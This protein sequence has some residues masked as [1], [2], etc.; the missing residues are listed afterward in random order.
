MSEPA[1]TK[2]TEIFC[3]DENRDLREIL[4]EAFAAPDCDYHPL[5]LEEFL[6]AAQARPASAMA[7]HPNR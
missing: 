7:N 5:N 1:G 6:A 2:D 3:D 4:R